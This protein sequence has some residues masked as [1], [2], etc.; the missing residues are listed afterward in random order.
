MCLPHLSHSTPADPSVHP[1][2]MALSPVPE[3]GFLLRFVRTKCLQQS[4]VLSSVMFPSKNQVGSK[5]TPEDEVVV[6]HLMWARN[7]G[8]G[9]WYGVSMSQFFN[10]SHLTTN[11]VLFL[12]HSA[13]KRPRLEEVMSHVQ[14]SPEPRPVPQVH[15]PSS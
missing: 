9:S 1:T 2:A 11:W 5:K 10:S 7:S 6:R 8:P 15:V 14:G 4:Y 12:P 3:A 13:V